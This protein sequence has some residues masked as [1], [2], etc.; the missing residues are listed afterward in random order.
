MSALSPPV[1]PG[2]I[3]EL[4]GDSH[5]ADAL[6]AESG[7]IGYE[8]LTALGRRFRRHYIPAQPAIAPGTATAGGTMI[9]LLSAIGRPAADFLG[10]AGRLGVFV[11][12]ALSYCVRPPFY[13]RNTLQ[14]FWRIGYNSLPVVGLTAVFIGAVLALQAYTGFSRF[15]A[16]SQIPNLVVVA[17]TRELGPVMASLMVA[18]RV[19]AAIAAELGTMRVTE[20]IDALETLATNPMK[21]L[22]VPRV[23]A[24]VLMMPLLVVIA[25]IIGIM[26]GFVVSTLILN[27]S[28]GQ[29]IA[30]TLKYMTRGCGFG[31]DEG[32]NFRSHYRPSRLLQR[33]PLEGRRPGC[34]RR[35]DQ[36]GRHRVDY[37]S[38]RRLFPHPAVLRPMTAVA[39][40]E[41]AQ[42]KIAISG[43]KKSFGRKLVLDGVDL[44]VMPGE[45]L[46]VIGGSGS[47]K[48]VLLKCI[49][50][51]IQPDAGSILIDGEPMTGANRETRERLR[52][53]IGMLFQGGAL[54]DSLNVW[55]NV[56]FTLM[57]GAQARPV[58]PAQPGPR[59]RHRK[60]GFRGFGGGGR[61][62]VAGGIVGRH[63]KTR[64]ACPRHRG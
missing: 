26:G 35:G 30:D 13:F 52:R 15:S 55:R 22:V 36:R 25:D 61:Q 41:P 59:H 5:D 39:V 56:S 45:S 4:I 64:G 62:F 58:D 21:Y 50:G 2:T 42:L 29:Y 54:F 34:R 3:V 16:S 63:A 1:V 49:L 46:V 53:K 12:Q 32:S 51:L 10:L 33:L 19:G 47:G 27:F 23:L 38:R 28:E 14:Q 7:T 6:A 57:E 37:D 8:V 43:L 60:A 9:E 11:S 24:G 17:I 48:S 40:P 18:G 44:E 31:I 20:Q